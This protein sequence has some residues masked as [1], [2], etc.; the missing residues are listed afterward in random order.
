M[1]KHNTAKYRK[2]RKKEKA[3]RKEN[4]QQARYDSKQVEQKMLL[5]RIAEQ[6]LVTEVRLQGEP[7]SPARRAFQDV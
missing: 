3:N 6:P 5:D 2:H 4:K 7:V 1:N